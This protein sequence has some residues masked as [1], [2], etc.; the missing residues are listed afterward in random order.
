[1]LLQNLLA[2]EGVASERQLSRRARQALVIKRVNCSIVQGL[3]ILTK[4]QL[5]MEQ[6][7]QKK[8]QAK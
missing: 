8:T 6:G 3:D 2:E 7:K 1:M 5:V 4:G